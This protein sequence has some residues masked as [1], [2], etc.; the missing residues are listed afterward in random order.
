MSIYRIWQTDGDEETIL[1]LH[2]SRSDAERRLEELQ[3]V[4]I[5]I[6]FWIEEVR[7]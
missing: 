3:R 7:S 4:V 1:T 2:T 6:V 5:T